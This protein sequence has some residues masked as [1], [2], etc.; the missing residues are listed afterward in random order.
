MIERITHQFKFILLPD[1]EIMR[2]MC[3]PWKYGGLSTPDLLFCS[4]SYDLIGQQVYG[5]E[6]IILAPHLPSTPGQS[7]KAR[8]L[9]KFGKVIEPG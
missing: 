6:F 2:I 3:V 1:L 8:E 4:S 7:T 9:V 5:T